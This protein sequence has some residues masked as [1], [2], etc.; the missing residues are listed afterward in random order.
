MRILVLIPPS[1]F[2]RNVARDLLY[3]CWCKGKRIAG[4]QF[5][6]ISQ[7]LVAT[8]MRD[9]GHEVK[10]LDAA[11]TETS[12]ETVTEMCRNFDIVVV[13][14][15]S[16]SLNEDA[17]VLEGLKE[18]NP[19]LKCV[20]YGGQVTAE[21]EATLSREGID[22]V[23]RREPEFALRDLAKAWASGNGAWE[24]IKGISFRKDG[25]VVSNPD[26]PLIENMDELPVPDRTMLAGEIDYFNPVVKRMPFTT[27]FTSRGCPGKCTFCS[28]PTFYGRNIRFRSAESVLNE[29]ETVVEQG[30]REV[31]FRDEIFTV[32]K[33]RVFEVCKGIKERGIDI[34]WI[35]SARIGSVT[36]EMMRE[37]KDAGCH[38]LRLGVESG[39]QELLDNVKKGIK[40]EQTKEVF[41]WA[42]EAGLDTHAHMMI[43]IPGETRETLAET[44][45]FIKEVD[46]TIV[47]FG[48]L[49]PY[50]G[51]PLFDELREVHPEIGDGTE[52]DLSRLHTE[53]FFNEHF[54]DL[55]DEELSTFI[56]KVYRGFYMR[57]A[58]LFKWIKRIGDLDEFKRVALAGMQVMEFSMGSSE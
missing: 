39:V 35:C 41:K 23:I 22:I 29:L 58:Y 34:T 45:D 14:T 48:I 13:L 43:G 46:P 36:L 47:T 54:T 12:L 26:Y 4:T 31:F 56:R 55:T 57:P 50:A 27:M 44:M 10:L 19:D 24:D 37:M 3:G 1:K 33:K 2:S 32:S 42:H 5:P 21:P 8:V 15:S 40:V 9:C 28:S 51:T 49:T 6:P 30:Y 18:S 11:G 17:E 7:L 52:A 16:M 20:V 38:M 53:S 25:D